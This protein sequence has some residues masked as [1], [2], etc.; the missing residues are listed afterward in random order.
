MNSFLR[1]Q[2]IQLY[3]KAAGRHILGHLDELNQT[4]WLSR[5]ELLN[6]QRNKLHRLLECACEHVPYYQRLFDRVGFRPGQHAK[7]PGIDQ[8]RH[9]REL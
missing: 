2:A 1:R 7:N 6:L 9:S 8:G 4:Q 3:Q 5:D